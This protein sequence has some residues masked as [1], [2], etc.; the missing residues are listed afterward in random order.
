MAA[1]A[2]VK[3]LSFLDRYLTVWIFAAMAG[4]IALGFFLPRLPSLLNNLSFGTA[5]IPI[6]I[7]LILNDVLRPSRGCATRN[8]LRFSRTGGF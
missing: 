7:G 5:N 6:A 3:R 8:C 4:G 2:P 1:Q